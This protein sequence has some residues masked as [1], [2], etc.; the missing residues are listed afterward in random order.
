MFG[1]RSGRWSTARA[2]VAVAL[3][4]AFVVAGAAP[5]GAHG[6]AGTQPT[7][8]A[9]RVLSVTPAVPGLQVTVRDLGARLEVRNR[10]PYDVVVLGYSGEPYL[11]VG[12]RGVYEN[13]RS[14]AV[15][16]DRSSTVVA[17]VPSSYDALAPPEWHRT[18]SGTV[19][20]W[21]DHRVHWMG[22]APPPAVSESPGR[23]HLISPWLVTLR[24]RG[25][26]IA[27]R[28]DLRWVPGPSAAPRL[29]LALLAALIVGGAGFTRRW[30]DVLAL[31]LLVVSACVI[32][33]IG[34]EWSATTSGA[35]TAFL[36]TAYSILGV[37]IALAA[38]GAM[39]RSR[40]APYE[41][42]ALVLVAAVILTFGSGLADITFLD[43]SQLPTT[44]P[45]TVARTLIAVV[46]GASSGMLVTAARKLRR[47]ALATPAPTA[48]P[49]A[50]AAP[51]AS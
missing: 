39:L 6:L 38:A 19:V 5:A 8:F 15:F 7:N 1:A 33:L 48:P 46:L 27:V 50:S 16:L 34:G 36:S 28:G 35:W 25:H 3:G 23:T 9:S 2:L 51:T 49:A 20:S 31:T 42:S 11:R 24:Y 13:R 47:P 37:A 43:R 41:A 21:H 29:L 26:D 4:G 32:A 22:A 14:P 10:T 12:P 40:R 17:K 30:G 45:G 44:L 18:G